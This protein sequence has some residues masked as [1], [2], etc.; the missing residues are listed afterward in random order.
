[1]HDAV[2]FVDGIVVGGR[3]R[4]LEATALIDGDVDDDAAR[5]LDLIISA[6]TNFGALAPRISTA[7][8]TRSASATA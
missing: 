4:G 8:I 5:L 1:M 2:D 6:V 3:L 7:P